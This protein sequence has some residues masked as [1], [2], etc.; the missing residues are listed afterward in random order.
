MLH[1]SEAAELHLIKFVAELELG[2]I[3][4]STLTPIFVF[5]SAGLGTLDPG[6]GR[7]LDFWL[8]RM[9]I[10]PKVGNKI[11]PTDGHVLVLWLA[12]PEIQVGLLFSA[13]LS[14]KYLCRT[15]MSQFRCVISP[16]IH[17]LYPLSHPLSHPPS[18]T[19]SYIH[20]HTHHRNQLPLN[21]S[22]FCYLRSHVREHMTS[23]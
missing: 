9:L 19:L 2:E 21:V 22:S 18:H 15:E 14:T 6:L 7:F 23:I 10:P 3:E 1:S 8:I 13:G 4:F 11:G 20:T 12:Y 16:R 17:P 5:C